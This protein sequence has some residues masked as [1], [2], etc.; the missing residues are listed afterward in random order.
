M[1]RNTCNDPWTESHASNHLSENVIYISYSA[2]VTY[3]F[4]KY[5]ENDIIFCTS[6]CSA[7]YNYTHLH[8]WTFSHCTRSRWFHKVISFSMKLLLL[9]FLLLLLWRTLLA[10]LR[11]SWRSSQC[12]NISESLKNENVTQVLQKL[13]INNNVFCLQ[14]CFCV[15][16]G[17]IKA[18][19]FLS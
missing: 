14:S 1:F 17:K 13:A 5:K 8:V 18:F 10:S 7:S 6:V 12:D 3:L 19:S 11:S 2:I 15:I 16:I 4:V 9:L